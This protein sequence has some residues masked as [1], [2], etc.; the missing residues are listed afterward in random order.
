MIQVWAPGQQ[1]LDAAHIAGSLPADE[2]AA[3]LIAKSDDAGDNSA[4]APA[5]STEQF[6]EL[7][8]HGVGERRR[9]LPAVAGS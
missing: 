7:R 3:T 8:D 6:K 4:L 1:A 5:S 9:D 2:W